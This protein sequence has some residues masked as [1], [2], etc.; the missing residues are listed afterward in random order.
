M[1]A[2]V[3]HLPVV[4]IPGSLKIPEYRRKSEPWIILLLE[5]FQS[6]DKTRY[7]EQH[8]V[9]MEALTA[10]LWKKKMKGE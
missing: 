7:R 9:L 5:T 1:I 10:S 8:Y 3:Y 2:P 6:L 4:N